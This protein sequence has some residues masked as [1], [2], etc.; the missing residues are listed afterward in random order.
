MGDT[1]TTSESIFT[2]R[3][4]ALL[5]EPLDPS[6]TSQREGGGKTMLT[7]LEGHTVIAQLNRLFGHDGW[8]YT[9]DQR[10]V[11]E[12]KDSP[13][14]SEWGV[15]HW[16]MVTLTVRGAL[17][18]QDIGRAEI[19]NGCEVDWVPNPNNPGKKMKKKRV[20]PDTGEV[21][22]KWTISDVDAHSTAL[23][24]AVTDALKRAARTFGKQ[25]GNGLYDPDG[26]VYRWM[27]AHPVEDDEQTA[28]LRDEVKALIAQD[29]SAEA[30]LPVPVDR[31]TPE[32][33]AKCKTWLLKRAV[34]PKGAQAQG[35]EAQA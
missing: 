24:G 35:E 22:V 33:L 9:I 10:G 26:D 3:L 11:I 15:L 8:G 6:L 20:N 32:Q 27:D 13:D 25:T 16:A 1:T 2:D 31:Q 21:L 19:R 7:Y 23:T 29:R 18:R 30:N 28:A 14:P 17:P 12:L 5:D 4:K 34:G